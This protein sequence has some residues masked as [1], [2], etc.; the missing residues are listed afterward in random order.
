MISS[1]ILSLK[2][3]NQITSFC[4]WIKSHCLYALYFICVCM[5]FF[6]CVHRCVRVLI[7][8]YLFM[9][10][11]EVNDRC[12]SQLFFILFIWDGGLLIDFKFTGCSVLPVSSR[13]PP[14][15]SFS[16]WNH[17]CCPCTLVVKEMMPRTDD[18]FHEIKINKKRL[19]MLN[20]N[21]LVNKPFLK[22]EVQ[23]CNIHLNG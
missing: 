6:M 15:A 1:F 11:S 18:G 21:G 13:D 9:C 10:T 5:C 4:N 19:W 20:I 14:I 23:M 8:M 7:H 2:M 22:C 17:R 16:S 3:K 12:L